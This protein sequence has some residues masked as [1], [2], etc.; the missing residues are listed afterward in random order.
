MLRTGRISL[1]QQAPFALGAYAAGMAT[2]LAHLSLAAALPVG[3]ALG[4]AA[5]A[6]AAPLTARPGGPPS[7]VAPLALAAHG[8]RGL[9][10]SPR[11]PP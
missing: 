5:G 6:F 8:A 9:A 3:A 11:R 2:T 10:S 7:A 4:L 1:G